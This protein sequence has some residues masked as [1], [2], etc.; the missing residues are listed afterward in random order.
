M[1]HECVMQE[2][3]TVYVVEESTKAPTAELASTP[4]EQDQWTDQLDD[5]RTKHGVAQQ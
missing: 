2:V 1:M 4:T 5:G 3:V